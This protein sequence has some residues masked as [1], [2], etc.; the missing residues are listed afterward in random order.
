MDI[1]EIARRASVSRTT[2][3]RYLNNG[4]VSKEKRERIQRV[5]NETGYVPSQHAQ[6][7]RTGKTGLVGV[8]IPKISSQSVRRMIAG[9]TEELADAGMQVLL[10]NSAN[11]AQEEVNFIELFSKR[12]NVDGIILIATVFTAEHT[13]A[14]KKLNIPL[15]I[16]GQDVEG[17]SCVFQDDFAA[18]RDLCRLVLRKSE[19][20]AYLGVLDADVAVGHERRRGFLEACNEL[21]IRPQEKAQLVVDFD[22]D[23]GYFGAER[24]LDTVDG[25]DTIVC[26]TDDIAFGAMMC[27]IEY[28]RRVPEDVQVTGVGDSMLSRITRPSLTTAHLHYQTSGTCAARLLLA[29]LNDPN[30]PIEHQKMVYE[31]YGR[32][33][34]R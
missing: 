13:R 30:K 24:L 2:V 11:D 1:N 16:L 7:L 28:G 18:V 32:S 15:V 20:P 8:I 23:A 31:V 21:G 34:M 4:Y 14:I 27:M 22:A 33:S 5:I 19:R 10:A 26:A 17:F 25:V 12:N 6:Q 29:H 9:I 3:S